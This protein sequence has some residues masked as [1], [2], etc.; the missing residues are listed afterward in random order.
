M[1]HPK[2]T[3]KQWWAPI[4]KGLVMDEEARHYQKMKNAIWLFL[5]LVLN[6][7]R[8]TG[9][10]MRKVKT[11]STDMGITRDTTLRW[12]KILR[13]GEYIVTVNTG[14]YLSIQI[15]KW[16]TFSQVGKARTQ[17][18]E[19]SNFRPWRNPTAQETTRSRILVHLGLNSSKF[20]DPNDIPVDKDILNNDSQG[21]TGRGSG[22]PA[23]KLLGSCARQELLA[24]DLAKALNDRTGIALY[25][26]YSQRYPE[27]LLR[28][29]LGEVKEMAPEQIKRGRAALFNHLVQRYAQGRAQNPGD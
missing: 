12:L 1:D 29:A 23:Y 19:R 27:W 5:Y 6:A 13:Q 21:Q 3:P 14:R 7:N 22:E 26:S 10:L 18:A 24:L 8:R 16:K 25:R 9:M 11:I 4:W 17:K 20:A 15:K 2:S 28:K